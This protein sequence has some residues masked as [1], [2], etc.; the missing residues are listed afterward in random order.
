MRIELRDIKKYFGPVRANDGISMAVESGTIH[1]LL[2][3][4]GAGKTTLMKIL[5]GYQT[6]DAGKI[7]LDGVE[8]RFASPAEAIVVGIGML[9][10]DPLDVPSLSLL[11]N[12]LLGRNLRRFQ[13]RRPG[14]QQFLNACASFGFSLDPDARTSSLTVGER[15]QL[16]LVRLLSL[17]A[18]VIILDEPTTGI[19]APQ[20]ALLFETLH[21]LASDGLSVIFVSHKLDEFKELCSEV[22][23]LRQGKVAGEA[24]APFSTDQLVQMMFGQY[25]ATSPRIKTSLGKV[26]LELDEVCIHTHHLNIED[27]S[28]TLRQGEV[29]GLAG[30]EGSG[31]RIMMQ[32]CAGLQRIASGRLLVDGRDMTRQPYRRFLGMGVAFLPAGRLEEGLVPGLNLREHFALVEQTQ[33]ALIP[34][35]KVN[36]HTDKRIREFNVIGHPE[37][38]VEDLSGGN[39][40]R[41]M[42]SLLPQNLGILLLE[43]PTRGLDLESA[44]WVWGNIQ[45]RRRQGTAVLF[46]SADLDELVKNSDRIVVFSGGIMSTPVPASQ[47]TREDLGYLIGGRRL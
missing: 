19:S 21:R 40:Q 10:Q 30:L 9:H 29:I 44:G 23:V 26:V 4:N 32:A 38:M 27:V 39:Q 31:Q 36:A 6:Y 24:S 47:V 25:A 5:S 46:T 7:L 2:G 34:W 14:R 43:H 8:V 1:G 42:L 33:G 3:E 41:A 35:K 18:Q 13:R 45:D 20:K 16:E 17:G 28:L 12:F 11:D 22:T 37:T 15:Q